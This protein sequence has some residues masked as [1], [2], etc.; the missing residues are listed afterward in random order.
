MA[1]ASWRLFLAGS[2]ALLFWAGLALACPS[3][4]CGNFT[5]Q[6]QDDCKF[7]SSQ[8]FN[9]NEEQE[10]F[11]ALWE[12][13]YGFESYQTKSYLLVVDL[14]MNAEDIETSRIV[15]AGK[16]F[17]F[18]LFNYLVFSATKLKALARWLA[19]A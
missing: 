14:S 1:N 3:L 4:K 7:I 11:C 5:G 2:L 19:V 6:K 8:G 18:G 9:E 13:E 16:I 12:G 17:L 10:L 15:T